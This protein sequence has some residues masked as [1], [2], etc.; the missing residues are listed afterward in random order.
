M[1]EVDSSI[2][3]G[4]SWIVRSAKEIHDSWIVLRG[5]Y[6]MISRPTTVS[7]PHTLGKKQNNNGA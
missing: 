7:T 6:S 2:N 4:M 1:A 3:K 5:S